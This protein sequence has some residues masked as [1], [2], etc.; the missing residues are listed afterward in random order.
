MLKK[1]NQ[2]KCVMWPWMHRSLRQVSDSPEGWEIHT[3]FLRP[4]FFTLLSL[5]GVPQMLWPS[6][7]AIPLFST[8]TKVQRLKDCKSERG[9]EPWITC[10]SLNPEWKRH[11]TGGGSSN[12]PALPA[13]SVEQTNTHTQVPLIFKCT[14][15]LLESQN[16]NYKH[17]GIWNTTIRLRSMKHF[18]L[19]KGV[20]TSEEAGD[21]WYTPPLLL[22]V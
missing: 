17:Y 20:P 4:Y 19:K 13:L 1:K 5:V 11:L 3:V 22:R 16:E 21:H 6:I 12:P 10:Q 15:V 2:P 9:L 8:E 7:I 18:T 14:E